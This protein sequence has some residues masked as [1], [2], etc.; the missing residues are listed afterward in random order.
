MESKVLKGFEFVVPIIKE[1]RASIEDRFRIKLDKDY[2]KYRSGIDSEYIS[3]IGIYDLL[4]KINRFIIERGIMKYYCPIIVNCTVKH[5]PYIESKY[6]E[7]D[8]F[9]IKIWHGKDALYIDP[10][11]SLLRHRYT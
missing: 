4:N 7:T 1:I 10:L 5:S 9:I 11:T 3:Y 6:W 2:V 8:H